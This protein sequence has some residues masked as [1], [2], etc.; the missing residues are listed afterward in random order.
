MANKSKRSTTVRRIEYPATPLTPDE[1]EYFK[2]NPDPGEDEFEYP[3]L[4]AD[5]KLALSLFIPER[6]P[7]TLNQRKFPLDERPGREALARVLKQMIEEI[8]RVNTPSIEEMFP[9]GDGPTAPRVMDRTIGQ[10]SVSLLSTLVGAFDPDS[11]APRIIKKIK[12]RE[13]NKKIDGAQRNQLICQIIN[14]HII[15]TARTEGRRVTDTQA[16][17]AACGLFGISDRRLWALWGQYKND[18][19]FKAD[20]TELRA[21]RMEWVPR[22]P[23]GYKSVGIRTLHCVLM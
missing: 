14:A 7:Y 9:D 6:D 8:S 5:L 13:G 11:T 17:K 2:A 23:K 16:I 10:V 15:R 20:E 12:N 19:S 1:Q 22:L 21:G 3:E 4:H 18:G